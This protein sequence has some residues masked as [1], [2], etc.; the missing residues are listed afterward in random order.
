MLLNDKWIRETCKSNQL[1]F[2]YEEMCVRQLN[3]KKALSYGVGS[4]GY[5]LR[6][7]SKDFAII[8]KSAEVVNPKKINPSLFVPTEYHVDDDGIFYVIPAHSCGLGVSVECLNIPSNVSVIC[9]GKSTY[10]RCGIIAN[11]TPIE[12]GWKGHVTLELSNTSD[13]DCRVYANEGIVQLIF[14]GGESCQTSY[15]DRAGK[16]QNQSESVTFAKV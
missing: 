9:T 4:F 14:F 1:I 6:L 8:S 11:V 10:A 3:G 15:A 13:S 5:D 16:Y 12:A 7:S 2:P